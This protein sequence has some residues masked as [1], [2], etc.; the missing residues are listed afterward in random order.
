LNSLHIPINPEA[1]EEYDEWILDD[2]NSLWW[3]NKEQR[4]KE[5]LEMPSALS[6]RLSQEIEN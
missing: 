1:K 6:E 4:K 3:Y 2:C 5:R